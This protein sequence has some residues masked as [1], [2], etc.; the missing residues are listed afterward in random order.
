MRQGI[1]RNH[2][3]ARQI[4]QR[5]DFRLADAK[6]AFGRPFGAL[7]AADARPIDILGDSARSLVGKINHC[8]FE[9]R[10]QRAGIVLRQGAR[11]RRASRLS[12]ICR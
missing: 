4:D 6:H 3:F 12:A 7:V 11:R 8:L 2:E 9:R 1:F 5:L 10:Q